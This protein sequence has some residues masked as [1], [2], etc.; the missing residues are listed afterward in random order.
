MEI[1]FSVCVCV[2][3]K[4]ECSCEHGVCVHVWAC[5]SECLS[6]G[7]CVWVCESEKGKGVWQG[8]V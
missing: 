4:C 3:F 6:V 8:A 1:Q 5:V 7:E 2:M